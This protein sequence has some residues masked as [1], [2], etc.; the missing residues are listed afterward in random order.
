M[1]ALYSATN[2][3]ALRGRAR[4]SS[5]VAGN[6]RL[7]PAKVALA[8]IADRGRL[9]RAV[10]PGS[11]VRPPPMVEG[12]TT[13]PCRGLCVCLDHGEQPEEELA[14]AP[15]RSSASVHS[16]PPEWVNALCLVIVLVPDPR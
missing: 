4:N 12:R 13:A 5:A 7:R 1:H 8:E 3:S 11:R 10:P 15:S 6:S 9:H 16:R 14:A 2:S